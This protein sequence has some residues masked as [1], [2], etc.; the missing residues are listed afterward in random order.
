MCFWATGLCFQTAG[1]SL[2]VVCVL[3]LSQFIQMRIWTCEIFWVSSELFSSKL[4]CV[5]CPS[6]SL[7]QEGDDYEVIPNSKFCV[8]RTANKDNSSAYYINGKK[9][10]F[11]EVGAVLRSHG[12]DLDHNRFLILQV[13]VNFPSP[14]P[15]QLQFVWVCVCESATK[16]NQNW[17]LCWVKSGLSDEPVSLAVGGRGWPLDCYSSA[18]WFVTTWKRC[19]P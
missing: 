14:R 4:L 10:T 5:F 7:S 15:A 11:R 6:P 1:D 8:S 9:A 12:I 2:N 18:S 17:C 13:T 19:K 3:C 16:Y